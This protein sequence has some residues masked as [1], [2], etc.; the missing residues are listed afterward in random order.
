[1]C[2]LLE[3][4]FLERFSPRGRSPPTQSTDVYFLGQSEN[5]DKT[6][7]RDGRSGL[8]GQGLS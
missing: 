8:L 3:L 5:I 1:M 6:N 4:K 2:P 7:I